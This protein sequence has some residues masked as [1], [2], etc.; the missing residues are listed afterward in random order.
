MA[1]S[2]IQEAIKLWID[3]EKIKRLLNLYLQTITTLLN[4]NTIRI[5]I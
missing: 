5:Q 2:R 4:L 3:S 1:L